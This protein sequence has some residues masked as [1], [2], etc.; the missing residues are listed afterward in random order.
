MSKQRYP[1]EENKQK[2]RERKKWK[3]N[4]IPEV[5]LRRG[6]HRM[7]PRTI[8]HGVDVAGGRNAPRFMWPTSTGWRHLG[9][10]IG[11]ETAVAAA[12]SD[13]D[14]ESVCCKSKHS[15]PSLLVI[16]WQTGTDR[17]T[18]GHHPSSDG[19]D[20]VCPRNLYLLKRSRSSEESS[21]N[22]ISDAVCFEA[23][24]I[25]DFKALSQWCLKWQI[26]IIWHVW[27]YAGWWR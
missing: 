1:T 25:W 18:P 24:C 16:R 12:G 26:K 27:L 20:V 5:S 13:R 4:P 14:R 19:R 9:I 23:V 2:V 6:D 7:W 11:I 21:G 15:I 8:H 3:R 17:T 10:F 22:R